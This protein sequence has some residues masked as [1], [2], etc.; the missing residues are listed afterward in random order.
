MTVSN[1]TDFNMTATECITHARRLL[2]VNA[3]EE[4]LNNTE[5]TIAL[6]F[7]TLMLKDWQVDPDL[8]TWLETEGTLTLVASTPSYLFGSGGAV[9]TIP[10]EIVDARIY[11]NSIDVPM[12]RMSRK[13]Y[14]ALPNKTNTGYPT[15]YFYD[16]QRDSGTLYV[17][18]SPDSTAGTFKYTYRR[19]IMDTD[20]G[21]D[22]LDVPPEWGWA[23]VTNLA[24]R[25]I[26]VY[27]RGGTPEGSQVVAEA[28]SSLERLKAFDISNDEGSVYM[29]RDPYGRSVY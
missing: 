17:W 18:P 10:F 20:A 26:P 7:L 28:T 16:R 2:G 23:V 14:N 24:R 21:V 25:L 15:N 29:S 19:R 13:T 8:G 5:Q 6:E 12:T 4:S 3:E 27:G 1:S 22:N 11:R 9:T